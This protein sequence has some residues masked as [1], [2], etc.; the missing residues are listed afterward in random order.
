MAAL[1]PKRSFRPILT[2]Q[3]NTLGFLGNSAF[4]TSSHYPHTDRPEARSSS[5]SYIIQLLRTVP[6]YIRLVDC[7]GRA[8]S[9]CL[10][11]KTVPAIKE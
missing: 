5:A 2:R 6:R 8:Y 3:F 9:Y 1:D 11:D 7:N 10:P 4:G